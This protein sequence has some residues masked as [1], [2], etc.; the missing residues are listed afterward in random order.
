MK[1]I[2]FVLLTIVTLVFSTTEMKDQQTHLPAMDTTACPPWFAQ[3]NNSGTDLC[4]SCTCIK[5]TDFVVTDIAVKCD[6]L[7]QRSY[8]LLGYCMTHNDSSGNTFLGRS[9]FYNHQKPIDHLYLELPTNISHLNDFMCGPLNRKG[10]LC[11]DCLDGFGPAVFATDGTCENCERLGHYGV[12]LYLLLELLPITAFCCG[13]SDQ[14]HLCTTEWIY[15]L[16]PSSSNH[17]QLCCGTTCNVC[18]HRNY[19]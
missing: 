6:Q 1:A 19:I 16:Q 18:I 2:Y 10:L 9:S 14:S 8:L 12:A 3:Q 15:T 7:A 4:H 11:R 17:I 5:D 13:I